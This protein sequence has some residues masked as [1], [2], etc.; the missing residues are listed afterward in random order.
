MCTTA[1]LQLRRLME[2]DAGFVLELLN[3][4]AFIA[5][6]GD[7]GVRTLSDARAYVTGRTADSFEAHGT[8]MYAAEV[9]DSRAIAGIC[10]FARRAELDTFDVGFA[11]LPQFRSQ[12]LAYE[13]ARATLEFG[14]AELGFDRVQ[15]IVNPDN[16]PSIRLLERLGMQF[17]R[18]INLAAGNKAVRVYS[19]HV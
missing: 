17:D 13:A 8:G 11:F 4:P 14:F 6:I 2:N 9:R 7:R 16:A 10:G 1:R 19:A 18:M 3:D 5:N 12:G 15:A